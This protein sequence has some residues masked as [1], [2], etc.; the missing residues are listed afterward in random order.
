MSKPYL[1]RPP[2]RWK[3]IPGYVGEYQISSW[4][5]VKSLPRIGMDGK[6]V[7]ER[8]LRDGAAKNKYRIVCL[9]NN[10]KKTPKYVHRLVG[11]AY[12]KNPLSLRY[13][14]HRDNDRSNN[15]YTNLEWCNKRENTSHGK[16][17][18]KVTTSKYTGV[19]WSKSRNKWIASIMIQRKAI[20]LGGFDTERQASTAYRQAL[21]LNN[22]TNKYS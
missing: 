9:Y 6:T 5:R 13:I 4:G 22:L 20:N 15:Y 12:R 16:K 10:H 19:S 8:I 18:G 3:A 17:H 21:K 11:V 14:N 1:K 7:K 2:E